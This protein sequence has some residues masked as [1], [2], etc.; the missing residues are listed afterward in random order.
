MDLPRK[1][2]SFRLYFPMT[3]NLK[4]QGMTRSAVAKFAVLISVLVPAM[5]QRMNSSAAQRPNNLQ[6]KQQEISCPAAEVRT[7]ITTAIPK[8]WWTTPQQGKLQSVA[9]QAIGGQKT[10]VC[11]YWAYGTQ[12]SVMRKFPEGVRE[13]RAQGTHFVC[14]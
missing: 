8:P 12:V 1:K 9:I 4:E 6:M 11:H 14:Q 2:A 3:S 7:D 10:L 13:C 5:A